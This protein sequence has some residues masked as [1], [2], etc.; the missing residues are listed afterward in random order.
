MGNESTRDLGKH[1]PQGLSSNKFK[2]TLVYFQDLVNEA[3]AGKKGIV[4][5]DITDYIIFFLYRSRVSGIQRV[6]HSL[7]KYADFSLV[8][9]SSCVIYCLT[10]PK[11]GCFANI[12]PDRL[13]KLL[14]AVDSGEALE[15]ISASANEIVHQ[16]LYKESIPL[17]P[18]DILLIPGGPWATTVQLNLYQSE[19]LR[20]GYACYCICYDLIP[21]DYPEFCATGLSEVFTSTYAKL[22][23]LVDGFISISEYSSR[24]L[25]LHEERHGIQRP[26]NMYNCW[27]LGDYDGNFKAL[28]SKPPEEVKEIAQLSVNNGFILMVSTIEPRKNQQSL[29]RAWRLAQELKN[30][31]FN[32]FPAL[33]FAGKVG[34]NS[35]DFVTQVN[36]LRA[37]DYPIY[38][39]EDI[40][41]GSLDWL[42]SHCLFSVMPSYVEGWGLSI[43]ESMMRGRVCISSNTSSMVEAASGIAPLFDPYNV[44]D[45][46]N[47]LLDYIYGDGLKCQEKMLLNYQPVHWKQSAEQF[48]STLANMH[49]DRKTN[50]KD[51]HVSAIN[52]SITSI[53]N[54]SEH[55]HHD[56]HVLHPRKHKDFLEA[57]GCWYPIEGPDWILRPY[58]MESSISVEVESS[59]YIV[60]AL[61]IDFSIGQ[62]SPKIQIWENNMLLSRESKVTRL[63]NDNYI[64]YA[65]ISKSASEFLRRKITIKFVDSEM[66]TDV[67][68]QELPAKVAPKS[69]FGIKNITIIRQP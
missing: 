7:I 3:R 41:D 54:W 28:P 18:L 10:H 46:A 34:W 57:L 47:I 69:W 29:L 23:A 13:A 30:S 14:E 24:R 67:P 63:P 31:N 64:I 5:V 50:L 43:T 33:V 9:P 66:M 17:S 38:I 11:T 59:S 44:R 56:G 68:I 36:C 1:S 48:Y 52:Q 40:S 22:S 16:S 8:A 15:T 61:M 32:S 4:Y 60:K 12:C 2:N 62:P 26:S 19:K 35:D 49:H 55:D 20:L 37:F 39:L 42:Y 51:L 53:T 6:V 21:I 25:R 65:Y 45:L 27:R 58:L